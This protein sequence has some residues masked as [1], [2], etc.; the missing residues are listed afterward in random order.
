MMT[1]ISILVFSIAVFLL[2]FLMGRKERN[3]AGGELSFYVL[4]IA[5]G[6]MLYGLFVGGM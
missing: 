6:A 1:F 5:W 2:S 4:L 3:F